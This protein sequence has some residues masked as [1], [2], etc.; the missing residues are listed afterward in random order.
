M[1]KRRAEPAPPVMA[2]PEKQILEVIPSPAPYCYPSFT[3]KEISRMGKRGVWIVKIS[4]RNLIGVPL[5]LEGRKL[6]LNRKV[7][8][9]RGRGLAF[10]GHQN[11]GH[12]KRSGR[13][14]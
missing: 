14:L 13:R 11:L 12:R 6:D 8:K 2:A 9:T 1:Q 3:R 5:V 10:L 4:G 7:L